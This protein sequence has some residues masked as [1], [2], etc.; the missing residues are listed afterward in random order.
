MARLY[1]CGLEIHLAVR[2]A[3]PHIG[4]SI[5]LG[6]N[7]H[8]QATVAQNAFWE[9]IIDGKRLEE[10]TKNSPQLVHL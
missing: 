1:F 2:E 3:L 6:R 10:Q 9:L 7:I 4:C 5:Y 8:R